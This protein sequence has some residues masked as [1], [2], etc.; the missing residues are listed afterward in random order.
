MSPSLDLG[1]LFSTAVTARA[2][3]TRVCYVSVLTSTMRN[4]I[5][6]RDKVDLPHIS[7]CTTQCLEQNR[8]PASNCLIGTDFD[9]HVL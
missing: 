6:G 4:L 8:T 9:S 7:S 5:T 1:S 2:Q 3:L